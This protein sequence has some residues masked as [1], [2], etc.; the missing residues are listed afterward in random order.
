MQS[1]A[2]IV[3]LAL[4]TALAACETMSNP[5]QQTPDTGIR[6]ATAQT[7]P[8]QYIVVL[9]SN[10]ADPATVARDLVNTAGGSLL[11]VY[12]SAIKGFAA[13]LSAPAAAA[14]GSNPLVASVE[15]DQ[16]MRA[17]VT[18][19]MDANGD[20]WGL[21]R[22]DQGALPLSRT[23]TYT[24][25][26]AGVHAYII[27]TGIWTLHPEFGGRAN[28]V[29]D[30][31]GA[32]GEDC[33]GHGTHVSGTIGAATYGV[34]KAV[35]LHGVRVL[36]CAGLGLNSDV[37]AGVD[38]V[39]ANHVNPAVANMSLGGGKSPALDQ[40]VTNLYNSGVFLA[41]AA[42]NDNVDACTES[43]SG[44]A[45]VFTV[46]ASTKT[47]A[48]ASYSNWGSCVEAYAP[49]SAIVSTYLAGTTMSLSG[50]SMATPH[51]V[52]V[53]AL[54]KATN[55]NQPSATVANWITT[56][57]TSG[58]ITGNPSGTPNLLLFKSTL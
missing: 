19:S 35:S 7:V 21:D 56:N 53:A 33:N 46:A 57:A 28:N 10:V 48:K 24:S 51:V 38:W 52:G 8:G 27:D 36:S 50:T 39:T 13:R 1:A 40:A 31:Y 29:F 15:P 26:G 14:L 34:A 43:P 30:A 2:R 4:L 9:Q 6:S 44:A 42:G 16:M 25:T 58:V 32:T 18:Q 55:G 3:A 17:D 45:S 23:Y 5:A 49:G 12:S 54:Y 20:P 47:D 11:R 41:V 37:I 22:I